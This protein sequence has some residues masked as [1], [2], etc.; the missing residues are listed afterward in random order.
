MKIVVVASGNIP[1]KYAHSIQVMKVAQGFAQLGHEVEVI[2]PLTLRIYLNK[3]KIGDIFSFYGIQTPFK[4]SLIP[5]PTPFALVKR[6]D[7]PSA[8]VISGFLAKLKRA[9]LVYCREYLAPFVTSK[10]G[11]P[12]VAESHTAQLEKGWVRWLI[13]ATKNENFKKLVILSEALREKWVKEGVPE[14]K[15][16]T[17]ED[18]VDLV[19]FDIPD[20]KESYR[21][22][23]NLPL[24]KPIV[25][26]CGHLYEDKGIE[27]ILLTAKLVGEKA[28]FVLVG[29]WD[30]DVNKWKDFC[31]K[32]NI[33]NVIFTGFVPNAEVPKYLKAADIL[34]MPYKTDMEIKVMDISSTSPLKLFEYMASKRPIISTKIPTIEKVVKHQE[35]ALLAAENNV[36]K[37]AQYVNLLIENPELGEKIASNAF[38][39]VQKYDWKKRSEKILESI[40]L[41]GE[42]KQTS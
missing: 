17:C 11:I 33:R 9:D 7:L 25:I 16:I 5:V 26:Y 23:L 40:G 3:R 35:S 2:A 36:K 13:K 18:G 12:T 15:I 31:K 1:S 32:N 6:A 38:S 30:K 21:R 34:M 4:V 41:N 39:E 28:E 22:E 10:L 24:D 37:L 27:H 14:E 8:S 29:G 20:N 19:R 42:Y